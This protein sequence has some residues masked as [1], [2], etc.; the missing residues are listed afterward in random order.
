VHRG[1]DPVPSLAVS[2]R[3]A[4]KP[5]TMSKLSGRDNK[6]RQWAEF[7]EFQSI[8]DADGAFWNWN[9]IRLE[10]MTG[11]IEAEVRDAEES[12]HFSRVSD[13]N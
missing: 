13:G 4:R 7:G 5:L 9:A 2:T 1:A 3:S 6:I 8:S 10:P 11:A 12:I